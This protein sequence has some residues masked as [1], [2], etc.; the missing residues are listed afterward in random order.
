MDLGHR[1]LRR[2]RHLQRLVSLLSGAEFLQEATPCLSL[3]TNR[4]RRDYS[5]DGN[6]EVCSTRLTPRRI[7]DGAIWS[8]APRVTHPAR[9]VVKQRQALAVRQIVV[10][11]RKIQRVEQAPRGPLACGCLSGAALE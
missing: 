1:G 8:G 5:L 2:H 6:A 11:E 10:G 7:H 4:L 3:R 9:D